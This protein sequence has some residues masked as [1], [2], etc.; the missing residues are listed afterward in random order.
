M[1]NKDKFIK[2]YTNTK[3]AH[4]LNPRFIKGEDFELPDKS[5]LFWFK[6]SDIVEVITS[7]NPV[8]VNAEK[9]I[10][11]TPDE[12]AEGYKGMVT[13]DS[14][15]INDAIKTLKK[16]E[17]RFRFHKPSKKNINLSNKQLLV[18]NYGAINSIHRYSSNPLNMYYKWY[19]S[20]YTMLTQINK[21]IGPGSRDA[22]ITIDLPANILDK[23]KQYRY[24]G[25]INKQGL[26]KDLI[27]FRYL[28]IIEILRFVHEEYQSK[29]LLHS[30]ISPD[31]YEKI[32]LVFTFKTG[33]SVI[34]LNQLASLLDSNTIKTKLKKYKS[35]TVVKTMLLFFNTIITNVPTSL[36]EVDKEQLIGA[37]VI[38]K[39]IEGLDQ[40]I[41][42][43]DNEED[44][45]V[46]IDD[47]L[48]E[49][50]EIDIADDVND[51]ITEE[52]TEV[53]DSTF[54][55]EVIDDDD[56]P[57]D[58]RVIKLINELKDQKVITKLK[59][60]NFEESLKNQAR[61]KSPY[62]DGMKLSELRKYNPKDEEI[63]SEETS[64]PD[65]VV[66]FDK[67][68]NKSTTEVLNKKY[69]EKTYK[70]DIVNTIYS[71]QNNSILVDD[72]EITVDKDILGGLE[73]H[74]IVLNNVMGSKS[75]I[76]LKLPVIENDG[77]FKLSGNTYRM[78]KQRGDLPLRKIS[79][80]SVSLSTYYGKLFINKAVYKK[81]DE[82][83]WF[84]K[85]LEKMN[86]EDSN[87]RDLVTVEV[88]NVDLTL[89]NLYQ[90]L[91]R[92]VKTFRYENTLYYFDYGTR[93]T[94]LNGLDISKLE[95]NMTFLGFK[96]KNP[97]FMDMSNRIHMYKD[98]GYVLLDSIYEHLK[99][100]DKDPPIEYAT[101][102]VY[103]EQLPVSLLLAY[104]YGFNGMMKLLGIDYKL[105]GP[106]ERVDSDDNIILRFKNHKVVIKRDYGLNDMLIAGM[107]SLEKH[108]KLIDVETLNKR[109]TFNTLFT[110]LQLPILYVNEI[111][112]ME[113]MYVDPL[114]KQTLEVM[115]EPT[116]FK[117][118]LIRSAELL[119]DDNYKHPNNVKGMYFKGYERIAGLMYKELITAIK[120]DKNK[121]HFSKSK[122]T[123]N[124][125]SVLGKINEDSTVVLLEDLNPV[126]AI[127][128]T[129]DTT[130]L[131]AGGRSEVTMVR[132]TRG[133]HESDIG[134]IS[135]S[136]KDAGSVG[137]TAHMTANPKIK[138]VRGLTGDVDL[139]E[140]GW[141]SLISTSAMMAPF[142]TKD[143]VKRLNFTSIMNGHVIPINDMRVPY[144]R[145][146]YET[147]F[148]L[149]VDKKFVISAEEEG[150][151]ENITKENISVVYKNIGK[152]KYK[153]KSWTAK[154]ESGTTYTHK[155]VASLNKGD[156][157][158]AGDTLVYDELFF[159]PDIFNKKRVLYKM[160]TLVNV[161]L[162]EDSQTYEDSAT[163]SKKLTNRMGTMTT[164]V[165]SFVVDAKDNILDI[166]NV[167]DKVGFN[168]ILFTN[169][170]SVNGDLD[171][172]DKKSREI[173]NTIKTVSPK[174]KVNGKV[175]KLQV[176]YNCESE[177]MSRSLK[178]I[179][180]IYD[181]ISLRDD[182]YTG[183]VNGSYSIE[184]K[185]LLEGKI[186]IKIYIDVGDNMSIGD[187]GIFGNQLKFT[188][189]E[190]YS[191]DIITDDGTE[192]EATF[193]QRSIAARITNSP[194]LIGTTSTVLEWVAKEAVNKYFK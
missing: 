72:H 172:L 41:K 8:M 16:N 24:M 179:T 76:Q 125:Y 105:I 79:G 43:S 128:Q 120:M 83:F 78:R 146:G 101:I 3:V 127:K 143:D 154:E 168:D 144:V 35:E 148:P 174:A 126:S 9:P 161:A 123:I 137:V 108:T 151:V 71:L 149:R 182:D 65:N 58:E 193:S 90:K 119:T 145:T 22:Y 178:K 135:E 118:L 130:Y 156:K 29:S 192:V 12:Y 69:L 80:T 131:G 6:S 13:K 162:M 46:N 141:T 134:I 63:N 26:D 84:K 50:E 140:D 61:K 4:L 138:T 186:E 107:R 112:L 67:T 88:D 42:K 19:N 181:E 97:I 150:K 175:S 23:A 122:I 70:K 45:E 93:E 114:S 96:G 40:P 34:N 25:D 104:Y 98:G 15:K 57:E 81:D 56:L 100:I 164:K 49:F 1:I 153:L 99:L 33:V 28:N 51:N 157:F 77:T 7:S 53:N 170:D 89:P 183:R 191:Y 21:T 73:T 75:T 18:F 37:N 47:L 139:D 124:P 48:T 190:V 188:V 92:Y 171:G 55:V 155:L 167:G 177:D 111:K 106:R 136:S 102:K 85:Q 62:G 110:S 117:K 180:K 163:I 82:G 31:I 14:T 94:I 32:N 20:F 159:E 160:G 27:N 30:M 113:T 54:E 166:V 39:L 103:K 116:T 17:K 11:L 2:D 36:T 185:P 86:A 173:L 187:K 152:K 5:I 66:V 64:L 59:R 91:S 60:D 176:R 129:E 52:N 109:S 194:D 133:V 165:K 147:V 74:R 68:M 95:K 189:G 132:R 121:S 38:D 115:K 142:A 44:Q 87:L 169:I 10:V 184:G 158:I